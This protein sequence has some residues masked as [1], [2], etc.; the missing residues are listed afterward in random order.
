MRWAWSG[1]RVGAGTDRLVEGLE[2]RVD[3]LDVGLGAQRGLD[4]LGDV[5][6]FAD[7]G[8]RHHL[9]VQGNAGV[10]V[11]LVDDDVVGL[12]DEWLGERN[13]ERPVAQ[14]QAVASRFEMHDDI[15]AGQRPTN[16]RFDVIGDAVAL[17]DGLAG[18][19][20]DDDVSEVLATGLAHP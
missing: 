20:R 2:V 3:V 8:V 1:R 5:M 14:V 17:D 9:E 16:R 4:A 13:R 10:A 11:V 18:R 7:G 15:A 19:D 12:A 6:G